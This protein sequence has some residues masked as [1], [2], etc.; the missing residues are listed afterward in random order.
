MRLLTIPGVF[1]PIS[2]S[3]MLADALREEATGLERVEVH[4]CQRS[5]GP[6]D[7]SAPTAS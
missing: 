1:A 2:D 3:W 7:A 4:A 5:A 6:A